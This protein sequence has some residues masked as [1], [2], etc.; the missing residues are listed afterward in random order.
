MKT[1]HLV[2]EIS[3]S[4]LQEESYQGFNKPAVAKEISEAVKKNN[5]DMFVEYRVDKNTHRVVI[6]GDIDL[7]EFEGKHNVESGTELKLTILLLNK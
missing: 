3:D 2:L 6:S 7:A 1:T 5:Y 4:L